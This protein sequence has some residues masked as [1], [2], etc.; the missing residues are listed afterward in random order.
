MKHF[1]G[2]W[3]KKNVSEIEADTHLVGIGVITTKML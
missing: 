3:N 1:L 2:I